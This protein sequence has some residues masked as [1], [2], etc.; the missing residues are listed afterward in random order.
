[1]NDDHNDPS[2]VTE[3]ARPLDEGSTADGAPTK[4]A[5]RRRR[6][7]RKDAGDGVAGAEANAAEAAAPPSG[8]DT[9][10]AAVE[11]RSVEG[12]RSASNDEPSGESP[13][14]HVGYR[15][16]DQRR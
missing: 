7:P 9:A 3:P 5:T 1:M 14:L 10:P 15:Q 13:A 12:A 8:A 4:P 11:A 2:T 16:R 6:A